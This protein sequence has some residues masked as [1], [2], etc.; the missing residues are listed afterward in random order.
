M[1]NKTSIPAAPPTTPVSVEPEP[2]EP[3]A[4]AFHY[5]GPI[6]P[7]DDRSCA[8]CNAAATK[9]CSKDSAAHGP[10]PGACTTCQAARHGHCHH[11]CGVGTA[12]I[13]HTGVAGHKIHDEHQAAW[14]DTKEAILKRCATLSKLG[15]SRVY[16]RAHANQD[17]VD[18]PF[19]AVHL[20]IVA[21]K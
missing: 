10:T 5:D 16:V 13:E 2:P 17:Q 18:M 15:V 3:K 20:E 1:A 21:Y 14:D 11:H 9:K 4:W 8:M 7:A 19:S 6:A 12:L